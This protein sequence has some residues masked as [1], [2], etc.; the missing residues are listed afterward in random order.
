[1]AH[2]KGVGSS[3]N[4]RD[5]QPKM[6]GVKRFSGQWV[7]AGSIL[8]RQRGT[9]FRPG[10]NVGLGATSRCS[11]RRT[12]SWLRGAA[13]PPARQH[14]R[15]GRVLAAPARRRAPRTA[16]FVDEVEIQVRAGDGGSGCVSFR[17]EKFVPR[18]GPERWRRRPR[19][20]G[21]PRGRRRP[22]HPPRLPI[23]PPLRRAARAPRRGLG[24]SRRER[25]RPGPARPRRHD[26]AGAGH[27]RWSWAISPV[28][29]SASPSRGAAA[30]GGATR[31]SPP[32][33]IARRAARIPASAGEERWLRLELRLLADVGV[34]GFPNAGKSTLV[35]RLSAARPRIADYPFTT[36]VPTLGLVRLDEGRSFVIADVPGLIPG[37]AEGKGL[38]LRFLRHLER[39]RLLVHLLDLDPATGR[40][41]VDDWRDDPGGAPGVLARA[42]RAPAGH[43]REQDGPPGRGRAPRR[44]STALGAG[45]RGSPCSRSRPGRA[46]GS[47]PS[48]RRSARRSSRRRPMPPR[49][50]P[51]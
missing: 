8:V 1:M 3:R 12:A 19:R 18:G 30:G 51:A 20:L 38:G 35:S 23:P 14:P 4:G 5:S 28:M 43:R 13:R 10:R 46:T 50:P 26:G 37:A 22:R 49:A 44:A 6:L 2:K 36:L 47:T 41:P 17:R 33:R 25:R 15:A 39:T 40:D 16:V 42:G 9:R 11:P 29:A 24:P 48:G 34:V 7:P 31:A 32:P 21:D 27:R 45:R